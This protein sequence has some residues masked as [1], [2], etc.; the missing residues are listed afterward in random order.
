MEELEKRHYRETIIHRTSSSPYSMY[1]I[2][3][4]ARERQAL[5][6]HWHPEA[7]L[8]YMDEGEMD[9]FVEDLSVHL[10]KGEAVFVPPKLLHMADAAGNSPG[11]FQALIFSTDIIAPVSEASRY[12]TYV[13]PVLRKNLPCCICLREEIP[14]QAQVLSDLRRVF[15][16]PER[17]DMQL[18]VEGLIR[19]IWQQLYQN[20]FAL[21]GS[22]SADTGAEQRLQDSLSY[23]ET[24]F[25]EELSLKLLADRAHLSE[26]QFCRSFK[27][28]TGSTPFSWLKRCRIMESCMLLAHT[29]KKVAEI[30]SLCGFNNISY[31][32]REFLRMMKLT[33]SEYRRAFRESEDAG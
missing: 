32:N 18:A 9:F 33:P 30:C 5:Y 21:Y 12:Q 31:Y 20:H 14:W 28:L 29:D 19:L 24:H 11:R 6:L 8:F 4:P 23:I 1:S 22:S 16:L 15:A 10:K 3:Y 17:E 2:R 25:Q 13:R 7:E 27:Q 26:G